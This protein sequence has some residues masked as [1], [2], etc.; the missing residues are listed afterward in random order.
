MGDVGMRTVILAKTFLKLCCGVRVVAHGRVF[1][2]S[3]TMLSNLL[4]SQL[5]DLSRSHTD[6]PSQTFQLVAGSI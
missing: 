4:H 6:K 1:V 5:R 2:K 3:V